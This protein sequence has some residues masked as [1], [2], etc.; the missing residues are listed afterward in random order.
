MV[1]GGPAG[2]AAAVYAGS[3]GLDVLMIETTA[4][5]GQAGSSS[6]I[7]NYLG[8]LTGISGKELATRAIV[9][10]EKFGARMMVAHRVVRLECARRP[11][12]L[13][14]DNGNSLA[15][16]AIIIA[17]GAQYSEPPLS[18]LDKYKGQRIS[19]APTFMQTHPRDRP[20]LPVAASAHST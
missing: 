18:N 9:Q 20:D 2:L 6:K 5:G 17:T 3:E 12:K 19:Y 16:R 10:A 11:F 13:V 1:G 15:A 4:P 14:L 8:F 7:E